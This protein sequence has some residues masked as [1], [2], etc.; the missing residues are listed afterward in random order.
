MYTHLPYSIL[1]TVIAAIVISVLII[2]ASITWIQELYRWR[3]AR[4]GRLLPRK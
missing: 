4:R 3:S 1:I 2:T